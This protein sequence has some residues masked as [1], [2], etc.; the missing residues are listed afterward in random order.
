MYVS[1]L[2]G[3]PLF[4]DQVGCFTYRNLRVHNKAFGIYLDGLQYNLLN[5]WVILIQYIIN[6]LICFKSF[7]YALPY[8]WIQMH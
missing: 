3:F 4:F 7:F 6:L 1:D 2:K 5:C 8:L